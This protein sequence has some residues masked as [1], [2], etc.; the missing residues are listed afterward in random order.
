MEERRERN[1]ESEKKRITKVYFMRGCRSLP[2][3]TVRKRLDG[4][5]EKW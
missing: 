1:R 3:N 4:R 2:T 5:I